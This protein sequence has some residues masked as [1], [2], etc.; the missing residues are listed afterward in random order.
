MT[1]QPCVGPTGLSARSVRLTLGRL[2]AAPESAV[3]E[4]KIGRNPATYVK[5]PK[6]TPRERETW[7]GL[8]VR[9]FR[10]VA[11]ADRLAAIAVR[12]GGAAKFPGRRS[13]REGHVH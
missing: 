3:E 13:R 7:T 9:R 4:G 10:A 2:T 12:P 8:E 11:D 6:H 1:L 5:P